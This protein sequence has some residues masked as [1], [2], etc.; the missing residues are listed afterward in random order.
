MES[1]GT[2]YGAA[3]I[4]VNKSRGKTKRE[5]DHNGVE[6]K[7][8]KDR[9]DDDEIKDTPMCFFSDQEMTCR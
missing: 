2:N 7:K 3:L 9:D 5:R 8:R 4:G 1:Y 6:K